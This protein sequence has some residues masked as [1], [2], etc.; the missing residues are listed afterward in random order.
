MDLTAQPGVAVRPRRGTLAINLPAVAR[1]STPCSRRFQ[2]GVNDVLN[3]FAGLRCTPF[4]LLVVVH[5]KPEL[6]RGSRTVSVR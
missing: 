1:L 3:N 4:Q 6:H 5:N 2:I